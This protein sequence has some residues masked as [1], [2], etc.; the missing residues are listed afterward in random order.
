MAGFFSRLKSIFSGHSAID[1]DFY[2]ELEET[3]IMGDMGIT[4]TEEVMEELSRLREK[5]NAHQN[6]RE[7]LMKIRDA[8]QRDMLRSNP[9]MASR[10]FGGA[11]KELQEKL[12]KEIRKRQ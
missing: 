11:L 4:A 6:Y 12:E 1:E 5:Y 9:T 10:R 3:L 8:V 7:Q 2:E